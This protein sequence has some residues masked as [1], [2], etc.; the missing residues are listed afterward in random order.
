MKLQKWF[1]PFGII[2][3]LFFFT[4]TI[5]GNIL[6]Q[7]YNPIRQNISELT[8]DGNPYAPLLRVF[9]G[10]YEVCF[11]IFALG[12]L[13]MAFRKHNGYIKT[14]FSLLLLT[15]L[16]SIAGFNTFPMTAV[17]IISLQN[18]GHMIVTI[19]LLCASILSITLISIG[20]LK[21]E[22]QIGRLLLFT[23]IIPSL[24][25]PIFWYANFHGFDSTGL[26]ERITVY[27]FHVFTFIVSW[28]YTMLILK[29]YKEQSLQR[30]KLRR[31]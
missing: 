30:T 8:A 10:I 15:A 7:G 5:L 9:V 23:A 25:N 1:I 16:I 29:E 14:G 27:P 26:L 11:L 17:F 28:Q 4:H 22:K 18:L 24:F 20:F 6:W 2:S 12:M 21:H 3:V 13:S 19:I 31:A